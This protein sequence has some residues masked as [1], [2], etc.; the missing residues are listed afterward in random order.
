MTDVKLSEEEFPDAMAIF[1]A[2]FQALSKMSNRDVALQQATAQ[3]E[4]MFPGFEERRREY[5]LQKR[6]QMQHLR[7]GKMLKK[8][9]AEETWYSGARTTRG[10]W[11]DYRKKIAEKLP[12]AAVQAIDDTTEA[13]IYRMA[14]P[15][16]P[17]S[18]RKGLVLGYV[19]SG[20]TANFQA[21]IAKSV[22]AGYRIVIVLA[23]MYSNLRAQ[24]QTRL[25]DDLDL[26]VMD[27][28]KTVYWDPKTDETH[29][30]AAN[31]TA[32]SLNTANGVVVMVVKKHEKRLKN[33]EKFLQRI[34]K[35]QLSR[36]PVLIIDDESDQ[37]TPNTESGRDQISTINQRL[38][39]IW[40]SVPTGSYVAYTATPFANLLISPAEEND[41]YPDD[42]IV[43]LPKPVGY[44][45]AD[46]FFDT[47]EVS[48]EAEGDELIHDLSIGIPDNEASVLVPR[49]RNIE[50]Y[51][52]EI[53]D[54]LGQ[55]IRWFVIAT[56]IRELRTGKINHSSMLLHTTH[57][58]QAH[59]QQKEVIDDFLRELARNADETT[60]R[61]VF[62]SQEGKGKA[63]RGGE[64]NYS[65]SEV[66][67]RVLDILPSITV[68]IDNGRS[69]DRLVY[70]DDEPQR[71]I[72]IGGGTL[73]R[74]LTLEGLVVSYFLRSSNAYDTLLQ[75]GRWFGFRPHYGDLVRVW[76]GPGLLDDYRHLA[77]V[78]RQIRAEIAQMAKENLAPREFAPK[79]LTHPGRLEITSRGKMADATLV[80]AGIGGTRRQTIYLNKEH[81]AAVQQLDAARGLVVRA[82]ERSAGSFLEGTNG[83]I[84]YR[85]LRNEDVVEFLRGFWTADPW[86]QPEAM[87]RW[88]GEYA[89][90]A[91]WDLVLVS[92]S[93]QNGRVHEWKPGVSVRTTRRARLMDGKWSPEKTSFDRP[94]NADLVNIRALMSSGDYTADIRIR[95]ENDKLDIQCAEAF[96]RLDKDDVGAVKEFRNR[97]EPDLGVL[98]VYLIDKDSKAAP[99]SKARTSMDSED[100]LV[101]LGMVFPH[102]GAE[103]PNEYISAL[104]VQND[105]EESDELADNDEIVVDREGDFEEAE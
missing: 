98:V 68:K 75:M 24:T 13:T 31:A 2:Y 41:F 92:G 73:S 37:A 87:E 12:D 25:E 102:A 6:D 104:I 53:T 4:S 80:H 99:S 96:E 50:N 93:S 62:E 101:G 33:I 9:G 100:D 54:T 91:E 7:M 18:Q 67:D 29:D 59:E 88:L 14:N 26:A 32:T 86:M 28:M 66:W 10:A 11:P 40:K 15:K 63:L 57:R 58:V 61:A 23:G 64:R 36:Y 38:R 42:F 55:A 5:E 21:L 44:L 78:E 17:G 74:G 52:P 103:D 60:M 34:P 85:R 45:G 72:A 22:D 89:R 8:E 94:S 46:E 19:Q 105:A 51:D 71:V 3:A 82:A 79:I 43:S 16:R 39:D 35:D 20:K 97:F 83:N 27:P 76:V 47:S 30:I 1:E 49:G 69:T 81:D 56:A 84:L 65:W 77:R 95:Y 70:P 48:D 90:C